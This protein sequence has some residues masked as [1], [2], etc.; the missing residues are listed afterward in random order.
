MHVGHSWPLS[1]ATTLFYNTPELCT[2]ML[3]SLYVHLFVVVVE[4]C[5]ARLAIAK[6]L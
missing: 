1:N 4:N 2:V 6:L 3:Y 5:K